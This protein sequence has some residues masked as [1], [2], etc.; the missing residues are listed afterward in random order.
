LALARKIGHR[1]LKSG[2]CDAASNRFEGSKHN[3]DVSAHDE[4]RNYDQ[5]LSIMARWQTG[6]LI[7][8]ARF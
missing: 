8:I 1:P 6:S 3:E 4:P 5:S 7:N 2:A